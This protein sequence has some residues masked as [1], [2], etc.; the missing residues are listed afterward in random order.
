MIPPRMYEVLEASTAEIGGVFGHGFTYSGHPVSCAVALKVLEIIRRDRII[1]NVREVLGPCFQKRLQSFANHT[2]VGEA[3]GIG[4]IGALELVADKS[5][6]ASFA[7]SRG[8]GARVVKAA[9]DHGLIVRALPGDIIAL[10]PP[11]T[12]TESEI[13]DIF[14]RLE[15]ALSDTLIH[16]S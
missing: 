2:L 11:L 13:H 10:C 16:V 3:R 8:I 1:E 7:P 5:S 4:L 15:R 14:D 12:V 9:L 6:G